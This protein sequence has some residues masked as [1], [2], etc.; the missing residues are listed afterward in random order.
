MTAVDAE[1]APEPWPQAPILATLPA[2][3]RLA[4]RFEVEPLLSDLQRLREHEWLAPQVISGDGLRPGIDVDWRKLPLRTIGGAPDRSDPGG[5]SLEEFADTPWLAR[6]PQ[7][8]A[9][10]ARIPAPLRCVR[11]QSLGPGAASPLHNDSKYALPWGIVRLHVPLITTSGAVLEIDGATHR[12]PAGEC[13]YADFTRPHLIRNTDPVTRIHLVID[14]LPTHELLALFPAEFRRPAVVDTTLFDVPAVAL[15][16]GECAQLRCAF[17]MPSSFAA[18]DEPDGAFLAD[19]H[20]R[21]AAIELS[22]DRLVLSLDGVPAFALVHV[23]AGELRFAGWTSERT[24][25]IAQAAGG[26]CRVTLRSRVGDQV[27][28]L[29]LPAEATG[30]A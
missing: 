28:T 10:L 16:R 25:Q 6:A 20:H 15:S 23:G 4:L 14:A 21:A 5:P 9:L 19:P 11:L 29:T 30:P 7:F 18:F 13:W 27:R 12:W 24:I 3:A 2:T 1:P 17:R 8:A 26:E 22:G